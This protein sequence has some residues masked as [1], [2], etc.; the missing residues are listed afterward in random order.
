MY[1]LLT[2]LATLGF[3][4]YLRWR[5]ATSTPGATGAATAPQRRHRATGA[6]GASR[7]LLWYAIAGIMMVYTNV[8][9]AVFIA[10]LNVDAFWLLARRSRHDGHS[11]GYGGSGRGPG[12]WG[13]ARGGTRRAAVMWIVANAAIAIA[14]LF[15]LRTVQ[16]GL[17]GASQGWRGALGFTNSLRAFFEYSLVA[18]HGVYYYSHDFSAAAIELARSRTMPA[19]LRFAELF[20]VQPLTLIVVVLVL[21]AAAARAFTGA[22]RA[23][24]LA[25]IVPLVIGVF[26]SMS[27]QLDLTRYFLF[28][29][30]FL[31]LL[32]GYGLTRMTELYGA[33]SGSLSLA[34]LVLAVSFGLRNY[35]RVEARDSD[36]RP[37]ARA[38]T[39]E[40]SRVNVILVKP[41]EATQPL[42][43]Y[44]RHEHAAPI[45]AVPRIVPITWALPS[46]PGTR[47]WLVL[48]YRSPLY[49]D[50][51]DALRDDVGARVLSDR[52]MA[53]AGGGV[54]L[55]LVE[56]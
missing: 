31:F 38:I 53:E 11:N 48:D 3:L 1:M 33:I 32:M 26:V 22:R 42:S 12:G 54:R 19:F 20:L 9:S 2:L 56:T 55:V 6:G 30:P 34:I 15:Y 51:P 5:D 52:Y 21:G 46:A 47:V 35:R 18:L 37:V 29:S 43:Y 40:Q 17:A 13:I 10:A 24:V 4:S 27:R 41:S 7:A 16:L 14:F 23:A 50:S 36:Y 45:R 8:I 25:V 39:S 44:L 28:A 49:G